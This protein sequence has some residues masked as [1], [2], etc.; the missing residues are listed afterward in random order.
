MAEPDG[1]IPVMKRNVEEMEH[2]TAFAMACSSQKLSPTLPA[3][4]V[5]DLLHTLKVI[6][7]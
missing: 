3:V 6:R 7:I 5:N 4:N 1:Q 2:A